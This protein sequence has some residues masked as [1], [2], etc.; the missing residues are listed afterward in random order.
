MSIPS[1]H[2]RQILRTLVLLQSVSLLSR[3]KFRPQKARLG[4]GTPLRPSPGSRGQHTSCLRTPGA[5]P[6]PKRRRRREKVPTPTDTGAGLA[7]GRLQRRKPLESTH[8]TM[9]TPVPLFLARLPGTAWVCWPKA[10]Q[11]VV[12]LCLWS[13]PRGEKF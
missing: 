8:N 9:T 6:P 10:H 2:S 1:H 12:F 3:P 13:R 5:P 7:K 4:L 11:T